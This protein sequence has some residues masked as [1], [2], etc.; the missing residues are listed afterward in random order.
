MITHMGDTLGFI[1]VFR[2]HRYSRSTLTSF[3]SNFG[4]DHIFLYLY[5][6]PVSDVTPTLLTSCRYFNLPYFH[7][8]IAWF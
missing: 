2:L 5:K 6:P 4:L 1:S 7:Q 3:I 8:L